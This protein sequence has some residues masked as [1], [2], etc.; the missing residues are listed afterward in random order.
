MLTRLP[1]KRARWEP[2]NQP[3]SAGAGLPTRPIRCTPRWRTC[4]GPRDQPGR[5]R[6]GAPRRQ[7]SHTRKRA[8]L[9][10]WHD[11]IATAPFGGDGRSSPRR[12]PAYR[13]CRRSRSLAITGGTSTPSRCRLSTAAT[14][15]R[16]RRIPETT[17]PPTAWTS[18]R[19]R[20]ALTAYR[21]SSGV[22]IRAQA[23]RVGPAQ[24]GW[25]G[26]VVAGVDWARLRELTEG[27]WAS[28]RPPRIQ[29]IEAPPFVSTKALDTARD[30][31]KLAAGL[32]IYTSNQN[33][34][35]REH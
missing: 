22:R 30:W 33:G 15:V 31:T 16:A 4:S 12:R 21:W 1:S 20:R 8:R 10:W 5:P 9:K 35:A 13:R 29:D 27:S 32:R 28:G 34:R 3:G 6:A 18:A 11:G 26:V 19:S 2:F 23:L 17:G 25:G 24:V 7:D 14:G